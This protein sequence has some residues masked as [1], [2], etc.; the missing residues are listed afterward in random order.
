MQGRVTVYAI[1]SAVAVARFSP[2][3]RKFL[4]RIP[5]PDIPFSPKRFP[6]FYGWVIL[7]VSTLGTLASIPGQTM[8]V[9]VFTDFLM[10]GMGLTRTQISQSYL[11]GTLASACVLPYAGRLLDR[12]GARVMVV[13]AATGLCFSL[14]LLSQT[15]HLVRGFGATLWAGMTVSIIVFFL[16]RFFGQGL[17]TMVSRVVI[18][19]WFQHKRGRA[20]AIGGVFTAFGFNWA[21]AALDQLV[22]AQ[23]WRGACGVLALTAGAGMALIG[24]LF[25]RDNPE[26]CGL[27]MDGGTGKENEEDN[28]KEIV[29]EFTRAEATRTGAFWAF[30]MGLATMSL[31]ITAVTFH[32][33]DIGKAKGLDREASFGLYWHMPYYSVVANVLFGWL[34]DRVRLK[35][36]LMAQML[37][38]ALG[39]FSLLHLDASWGAELFAAGFGVAGGLFGVLIS[40]AY[41]RYFGREHLGA[42]SGRTLSILVLA[43][44]I[45]PYLFS[46]SYDLSGSYEPVVWACMLMPLAVFLAAWFVQNPQDARHA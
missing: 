10:H 46:K 37:S 8:G 12:I 3:Q 26:E 4:M 31:V 15:D 6:F 24:A 22:A 35:W 32:L 18:G 27:N 16:L 45:G 2:F 38:A 33:S 14:L 36:L 40:V 7:A 42:I 9:G 30:T 20:V 13:L 25:F 29:R 1:L 5:W 28:E 21:P 44:A 39:I 11:L 17:L 34:S 43:S 19:K 23:G 41:P